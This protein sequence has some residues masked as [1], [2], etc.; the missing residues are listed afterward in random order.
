MDGDGWRWMGEGP[1]EGCAKRVHWGAIT[2]VGAQ[3]NEQQSAI[4]NQ[5][6]QSAAGQQPGKGRRRRSQGAGKGQLAKGLGAGAAF[7]GLHGL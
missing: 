6:Q 2:G 3:T 1:E 5:Q 4:S 7:C